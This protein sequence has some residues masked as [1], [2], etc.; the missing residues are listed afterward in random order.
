[1]AAHD[2]DGIVRL[3]EVGAEGQIFESTTVAL[4]DGAELAAGQLETI[5]QALDIDETA[6]AVADII[7]VVAERDTTTGG[8]VDVWSLANAPGT[9][10]DEEF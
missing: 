7:E 9:G 4:G 8:D 5:D 2:A 3:R 6:T 10:H 1:M